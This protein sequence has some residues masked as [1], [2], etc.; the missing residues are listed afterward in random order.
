MKRCG[1]SGDGS[2]RFPDYDEGRRGEPP[3]LARAMA[4]LLRDVRPE[5]RPSRNIDMSSVAAVA[6]QAGTTAVVFDGDDIS[7][8][9]RSRRYG[10]KDQMRQADEE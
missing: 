6:G 4:R 3:A 1:T 5:G 8:R 2:L 7:R 10:A 9:R